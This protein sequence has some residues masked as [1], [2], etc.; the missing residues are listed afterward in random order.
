MNIIHLEK[1]ELQ[2]SEACEKEGSKGEYS[3]TIGIK[4]TFFIKITINPFVIP[5]LVILI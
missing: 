4:S 5:V 1:I 3:P 2:S